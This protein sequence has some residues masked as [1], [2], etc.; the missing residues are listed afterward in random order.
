MG[1]D[2]IKASDDDKLRLD[3][4]KKLHICFTALHKTPS[5]I[6]SCKN[7]VNIREQTQMTSIKMMPSEC[8]GN[9]INEMRNNIATFEQTVL[10]GLPK[11]DLGN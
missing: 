1:L 11:N 3:N 6:A 7:Q 8:L 10:K 2:N 9:V 4:I 5:E